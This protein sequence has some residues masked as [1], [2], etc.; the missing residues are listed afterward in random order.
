MQR[1]ALANIF[2]GMFAILAVLLFAPMI[3]VLP[4]AGLAAILVIAGVQSINLPRIETVWQT[5]LASQGV[6]IFTF[7]ATLALPI[8]NAVFLGVLLSISGACVS[9]SRTG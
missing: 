7:I 9:R 6:M 1:H 4:M 3:E 8:Q 5:G 2:T